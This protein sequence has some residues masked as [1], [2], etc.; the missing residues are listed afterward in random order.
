MKFLKITIYI[1]LTLLISVRALAQNKTNIE[2]SQAYRNISVTDTTS[3]ASVKWKDYFKE[4]ELIQLIDEALKKNNDLLI[5]EKNISI[6]NLQYK[7][8]KWG[9]V[10]QIN[11]F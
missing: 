11:A 2:V 1:V 9:N 8:T 5:V 10:P 7:Q 3:I 6:A 4:K